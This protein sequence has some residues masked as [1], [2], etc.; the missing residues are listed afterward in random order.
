MQSKG[1]PSWRTVEQ[2]ISYGKYF[3]KMLF[4]LKMG[5][6]DIFATDNLSVH[7]TEQSQG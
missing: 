5:K 7:E 6:T 4:L 2:N 1:L 3:S